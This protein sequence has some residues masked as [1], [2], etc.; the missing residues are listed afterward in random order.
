[1]RRDASSRSHLTVS[2]GSDDD[3][4]TQ[5]NTNRKTNNDDD[6]QEYYYYDEE[7]DAESLDYCSSDI[8]AEEEEEAEDHDYQNRHEHRA[9]EDNDDD[10]DDDGNNYDDFDASYHSNSYNTS[11]SSSN[12]S[13]NHDSI[14]SGLSVRSFHEERRIG[15]P[16]GNTTDTDSPIG[17]NTRGG[18]NDGVDELLSSSSL[19]LSLSSS[20]FVLPLS[21]SPPSSTHRR[22]GSS[23]R[24]STRA[25]DHHH[26]HRGSMNNSNHSH[27]SSNRQH[28]LQGR[29]KNSFTASFLDGEGQDGT[30][31]NEEDEGLHHRHQQQQQQQQQ[32]QQQDT[33]R[34][35]HQN[36]DSPSNFRTNGGGRNNV[37]LRSLMFN[38]EIAAPQPSSS[39]SLASFSIQNLT[40][41]DNENIEDNNDNDDDDANASITIGE[42]Y[43]NTRSGTNNEISNRTTRHDNDQSLY[44]A[45]TRQH[46]LNQTQRKNRSMPS[47]D[48]DI[49]EDDYDE[50]YYD[51]TTSITA[52]DNKKDD[53][54]VPDYE[55]QSYFSSA[56]KNN[57]GFNTMNSNLFDDDEYMDALQ[58]QYQQQLVAHNNNNSSNDFS[59]S[60]TYFDNESL[61]FSSS[62]LS[63][64][65]NSNKSV[66]FKM[67]IINDDGPDLIDRDEDDRGIR[68]RVLKSC[69]PAMAYLHSSIDDKKKKNGSRWKNTVDLSSPSSMST[70]RRNEIPEVESDREIT[71]HD[72]DIFNEHQQ[73]SSAGSNTVDF[74]IND[75]DGIS[76]DNSH[77]TIINNQS[78]RSNLITLYN[79]DHPDNIDEEDDMYYDS[80]NDVADGDDA[81]KKV[82]RSLLYT[83]GGMALV[84]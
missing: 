17:G 33:R 55:M 77:S 83:V 2:S 41:K 39:S 1:M 8:E 15:I 48:D 72:L 47:I 27:G 78:N 44:S 7:E 50:D 29:R 5:N 37:S 23:S 35:R 30:T 38:T 58:D 14:N 22:N 66:R 40:S 76:I 68:T 31:V 6:G 42:I 32:E 65:Q 10:D 79:D 69:I 25:R 74:R 13:S 20:L 51:A 21:S 3:D 67:D 9:V 53:D 62:S 19:S 11:S 34:M 24:S 26:Q 46:A 57:S 36:D 28:R 59:G 75:T 12:C 52:D 71:L 45:H 81:E 49:N 64:R 61:L 73:Y 18:N 80:D 4:I 60:C 82:I 70:S 54:N 63:G 16:F 84:G 43:A 56:S